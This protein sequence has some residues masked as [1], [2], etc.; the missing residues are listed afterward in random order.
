MS[1]RIRWSVCRCDRAWRSTRRRL[2]SSSGYPRRTGTP[3]CTRCSRSCDVVGRWYLGYASSTSP[4]DFRTAASNSAR[5]SDMDTG[6]ADWLQRTSKYANT[7]YV[8]NE[9]ACNAIRSCASHQRKEHQLPAQTRTSKVRLVSM[10]EEQL[11][12]NERESLPVL[13]VFTNKCF[14]EI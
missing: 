3:T 12:K 2:W 1:N 7:L 6:S 5:L 8:T 11:S 4:R 13:N 10:R 14:W 9:W